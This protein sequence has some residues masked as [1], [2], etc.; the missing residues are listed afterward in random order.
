MI[1]HTSLIRVVNATVISGTLL[2]ATGCD[3]TKAAPA[4]S[5]GV[6]VL[7]AVAEQ[8]DVPVQ[9][10]AIGAVEAYSTVSVKTQIT[11]ELTGVYF[12]EGDDVKQGQLL[13]SLD[14][15]PFE[16]DL[17]RQEGN[18]A[19]DQAQAANA[20]AQQRRYESLV[21]AGVVSS[22]DYDQY[23]TAASALDAAVEADKA[24]V[25]NARVQLLYCSIYSPINGRTGNLIV[26]RGNMIKANDNPPLVNINQVQP[27]YVTFTV[28]EQYLAE[29]KQLSGKGRLK[30]QAIVPNDTGAVQ[31]TLS[32]L[33]NSVDQTTGTI[34]LKGEFPNGD[35]RLWP[36]QFVDALLTLRVQPKA[37]VV[38][39][40]AIQNG[41]QGQ[42]VFVIK[43]DSTVESR[44]VS[45]I[46]GQEGQV[47]VQQGL[48]PG[49]QVVTDGQL[50]LLPGSKVQIKQASEQKPTATPASGI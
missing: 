10:R 11:G 3:R 16:A 25:E 33:D 21:K 28:P 20:R 42:F 8:K 39:S 9:V 40:Q 7:A 30:V 17:K 35:R 5:A 24:A 13:F 48:T 49:E 14:K 26:H 41:Q 37:I 23:A 45:T 19:R 47:I 50:R 29:I 6:P 27:I 31:G 12:K 43:K 15:R 4:P 22:Q 46:A 44:P 2:F 1:G 34:K 32:F 38:P 18:L 36:G